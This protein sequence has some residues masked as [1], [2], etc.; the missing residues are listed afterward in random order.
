VIF[1]SSYRDISNKD[2]LFF[3]SWMV[4]KMIPMFFSPR[5]FATEYTRP[6]DSTT[7]KI[8]MAPLLLLPSLAT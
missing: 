2:T 8:F 3:Y 6:Y 7:T 5:I 1:R 4:I